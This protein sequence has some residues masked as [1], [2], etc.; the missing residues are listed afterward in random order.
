ML[1]ELSQLPV[2]IQQYILNE[3]T[4]LV[5]IVNNGQVIKNLAFSE[6]NHIQDAERAYY[7]HFYRHHFDIERMEEVIG[8]TDE[9]GCAKHTRTIPKGLASDFNVFHQWMLEKSSCK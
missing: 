4:E 5:Q 3:Q 7:E 6:P 2:A 9:N 8:E 1:I